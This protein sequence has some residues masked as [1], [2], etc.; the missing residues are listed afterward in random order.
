MYATASHHRCGL[1]A[2][3]SI[4][5]DR[6]RTAV[7]GKS[8]EH[9][10]AYTVVSTTPFG[11]RAVAFAFFTLPLLMVHAR[12]GWHDHHQAVRLKPIESKGQGAAKVCCLGHMR[13]GFEG[14]TQ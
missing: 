4:A 11:R 3:C 9:M 2:A 1:Q 6:A 7:T 14:G 5:P 10:H 8:Y 13:G 12:K